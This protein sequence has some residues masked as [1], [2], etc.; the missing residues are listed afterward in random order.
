MVK[1]FVD[2]AFKA[3]AGAV[4]VTIPILDYVAKEKTNGDVCLTKLTKDWSCP[5]RDHYKTNLVRSKPFKNSDLLIPNLKDRVVYQDEF[6]H[7]LKA[8][9]QK[10]IKAGKKIFSLWITNQVFGENPILG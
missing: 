3:N 4:L 2:K 1:A 10:E 6:V 9:Y 8:S 5:N 7:W